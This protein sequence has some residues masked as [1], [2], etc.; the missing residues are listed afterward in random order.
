MERCIGPSCYGVRHGRNSSQTSYTSCSC[1]LHCRYS[2][3]YSWGYSYSWWMVNAGVEAGLQVAVW[4][5]SC[6]V[7]EV[8]QMS[9]KVARVAKV[10]GVARVAQ[11]ASVD[12]VPVVASVAEVAAVPESQ[13]SVEGVRLG[14]CLCS[15]LQQPHCSTR[16]ADLQWGW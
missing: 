9:T 7:L 1:W 6:Q 11:V 13:H 15:N 8:A 16:Q 5:T 2:W 3:G 14:V 12:R 10:A 4:R